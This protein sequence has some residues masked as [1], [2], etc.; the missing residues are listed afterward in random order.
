MR[1]ALRRQPG[2]PALGGAIPGNRRNARQQRASCQQHRLATSNA[3]PSQGRGRH[4]RGIR[5]AA[6][7]V[8][9]KS[10]ISARDATVWTHEGRAIEKRSP[11][12]P[13][14]V[15]NTGH[16]TSAATPLID[17]GASGLAGCPFASNK[18]ESLVWCETFDGQI[19]TR[20][21][22]ASEPNGSEAR[23]PP[24]SS[25]PRSTGK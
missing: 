21:M 15:P 7:R 10:R 5:S 1:S 23:G 6:C 14:R 4:L 9:C 3:Q 18:T 16:E 8:F 24:T 12:P 13:L 25:T 17:H 20:L 22:A 11:A 2:S 19:L